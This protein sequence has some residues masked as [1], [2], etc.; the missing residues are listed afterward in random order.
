MDTWV[1]DIFICFN[2]P[3]ARLGKTA[4]CLVSSKFY[5]KLFFSVS[6]IEDKNFRVTVVAYF[7]ADFNLSSYEF[8]YLTFI[9]WY[10]VNLY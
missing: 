4:I 5:G 10:S 7:Y 9:L 6:I 8:G 1:F 2:E 3:F